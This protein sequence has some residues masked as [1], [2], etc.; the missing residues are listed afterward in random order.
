MSRAGLAQLP[1][2]ALV[3]PQQQAIPAATT[4]MAAPITQGLPKAEPTAPGAPAVTS[5]GRPQHS[6]DSSRKPG[7]QRGA[8]ALRAGI[9]RNGCALPGI[10]QVVGVMRMQPARAAA[11]SAARER[12]S[13]TNSATRGSVTR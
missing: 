6:T 8:L 9:A 7:G 5:T 12:A 3:A 1:G 4:T 13:S 11:L 2:R 10:S